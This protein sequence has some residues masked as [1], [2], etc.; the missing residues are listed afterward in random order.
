MNY[1]PLLAVVIAVD[2]RDI[3]STF[4]LVLV[5]GSKCGNMVLSEKAAELLQPGNAVVARL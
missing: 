1:Q 3:L 5:A 2:K 4:A